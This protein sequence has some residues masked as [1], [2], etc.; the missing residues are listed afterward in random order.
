MKL[1]CIYIQWLGTP[2]LARLISY[3][4]QHGMEWDFGYFT[5]QFTYIIFELIFP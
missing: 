1:C 5:Q 3:N 4:D 2:T